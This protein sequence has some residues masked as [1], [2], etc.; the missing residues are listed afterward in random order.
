MS[1]KEELKESWDQ[2]MLVVL[3]EQEVFLNSETYK[4]ESKS[5]QR[6]LLNGMV[7]KQLMKHRSPREPKPKKRK[8]N[9]QQP[10]LSSFI[11]KRLKVPLTERIVDL[12]KSH[13]PRIILDMA[14]CEDMPLKSR[15]SLYAQFQTLHVHNKSAIQPCEIMITSFSEKLRQE[16]ESAPNL[17][18]KWIAT[19]FE[20]DSFENILPNKEDIVYLTADSDHELKFFDPSKAYVIGGIVDRNSAKGATLSKAAQ[21]GIATAKLP[22]D[23]Y[24]SSKNHTGKKVLTVNQ[25]ASII[26][27]FLPTSSWTYALDRNL[28]IRGN[29]DVDRALSWR[30]KNA[31]PKSCVVVGGTSG[32]GFEFARQFR[33]S[34]WTVYIVG[35]NPL[36]TKL[37]A[38]ELRKIIPLNCP[39]DPVVVAINEDC[40]TEV[41][42]M[43]LRSSLLATEAGEIDSIILSNG[44]FKWDDEIL[45]SPELLH[46]QNLESKKHLLLFLLPLLHSAIKI[47]DG[48]YVIRDGQCSTP[49]DV[50]IVGS[51]AGTCDFSTRVSETEGESKYI[52]SMQA[53]RS[54]SLQLKSDIASTGVTV[55]LLEPPLLKSEMAKKEFERIKVNWDLVE[56]VP[57]YVAG[58]LKS[59]GFQFLKRL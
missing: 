16:F 48:K 43:R 38:T 31:K 10:M 46:Q 23:S 45:E 42:S 59:S 53:L 40:S 35:R 44:L 57:N 5:A 58:I 28:P 36:K 24:F 14:Y 54:W 47:N 4:S 19:R 22:L 32:I 29:Q 50:V 2:A 1:S 41:G 39:L 26:L 55:Q 7:R 27:D 34:G 8:T 15:L 12:A 37:A 49:K 9:S 20:Q 52:A 33:L 25:V 56:T 6:R 30:F 51:D 17:T 21:L 18:S 11:T 3:D 13:G